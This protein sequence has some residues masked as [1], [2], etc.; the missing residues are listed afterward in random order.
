MLSPFV[1]AFVFTSAFFLVAQSDNNQI[2]TDYQSLKDEV[3]FLRESVKQLQ[4]GIA[5]N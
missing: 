2:N 5:F 4:E 3:Q 1:S